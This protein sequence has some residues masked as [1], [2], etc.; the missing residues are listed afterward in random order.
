[1]SRAGNI[2]I[3]FAAS[4]VVLSTMFQV[5]YTFFTYTT[6]VNAV[7]EGARYASLHAPASAAG[8]DFAKSVRNVVVYGESAPAAGTPPVVNGLSVDDVEMTLSPAGATVSVRNFTIDATF[9]K[10]KLDGRPTVT[11]PLCSGATQ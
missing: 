2:L 3:E 5:G 9:T 11:F 10:L 6:L 4:L 1:M 7:R 8:Q